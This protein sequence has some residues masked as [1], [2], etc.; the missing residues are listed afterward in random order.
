MYTKTALIIRARS[1]RGAAIVACAL[2]AST[3]AGCASYGWLPPTQIPSNYTEVHGL[4]VAKYEAK[5]L[6]VLIGRDARI[7]ESALIWGCTY[8]TNG[9]VVRIEQDYECEP[10]LKLRGFRA[11]SVVGLPKG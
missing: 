4:P 2:F 6:A 5:G 8:Q 1:I 3:V 10:A 7:F 11:P 9:D